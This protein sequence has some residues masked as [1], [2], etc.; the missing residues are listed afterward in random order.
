M[1]LFGK[2][3]GWG[4]KKPGEEAKTKRQKLSATFLS[5]SYAISV[6]VLVC[7]AMPAFKVP[8]DNFND[9]ALD[10][11]SSY[12]RQAKASDWSKHFAWP[13]WGKK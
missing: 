7:A 3:L 10:K 9:G 5:P 1:N 8:V 13:H 2:R 11:L 6:G 4:G 12:A